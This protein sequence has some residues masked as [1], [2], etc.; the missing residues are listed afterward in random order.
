[1]TQPF[2]RHNLGQTL[3]IKEALCGFSPR[4]PTN[5]N[6]DRAK[7]VLKMERKLRNFEIFFLD[8]VKMEQA[9]ER[10]LI[11]NA[12]KAVHS[13]KDPLEKLRQHCLARGVKGI[14]AL[15]R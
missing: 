2:I 14:V 6:N 4:R 15:G 10:D 13:A 9:H 1:M 8:R 12:N 11:N 7:K 3:L 5:C